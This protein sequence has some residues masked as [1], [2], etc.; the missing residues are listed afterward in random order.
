MFDVR[1]LFIDR[2]VEVK[3]GKCETVS[4]HLHL[5]TP[6]EKSGRHSFLLD[7][8]THFEKS[9]VILCS[10]SLQTLTHDFNFVGVFQIINMGQR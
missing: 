7:V 5:G 10:S 2:R 9:V 8:E 3:R 4:P 1:F 6:E